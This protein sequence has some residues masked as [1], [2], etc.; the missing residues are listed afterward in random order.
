[1]TKAY[2]KIS[3][4]KRISTKT[5]VPQSE[6]L[7]GRE[8]DMVKNSAGGFVFNVSD[9]TRLDRFLILGSEGGTYYVGEREL[10]ADNANAV[11]AL[12]KKHG[13]K[14][15]ARVVEIS[16]SGRA[17]KNDPALFVLALCMT[18]GDAPTQAAAYA[19]ISQ[20]ARIGTHVLHLADYV[21]NMRGWGRG[22]RRAFGNWYTNQNPKGLAMNL[23]KYTNRDGWTHKDVLRLAHPKSD[24]VYNQLFAYATG[25]PYDFKG[26]DIEGFMNAVE[27]V[28]KATTAQAVKL[29]E[30]YQLPREVLPTELLNEPKV[31]EALLPHMGLTALVR[32][33]A[34]MTRLGLIT[35]TSDTTKLILTKVQSAEE[36]KKARFHPIQALIALKTYAAGHGLRGSNVW[37]PVPRIVDA[38]DG[39]FY[40]SFG[41]IIPTGKRILLALDVSG[42]MSM[43]NVNGIVGL[44]PREVSAAMAMIT[45]KTESEYEI[46]GFSHRFMP[47]DISPRR[48]LD[49]NVRMITGLPFEGTDCALPMV[50][51]TEKAK[52]FDAF[53]IYTDNE[54]WF[55]DI[56][57]IAALKKYRKASGI[58]AKLAVVG[59]TATNFSIA[60]PEDA[61]SMDVVGFDASV[62]NILSDFIRS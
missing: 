49:D 8:S 62:P 39:M 24:G 12:I 58:N 35:A 48:R 53:V 41:N 13:V 28:K 36:L 11:I 2:S 9:F 15:V 42:S 43:D 16:D 33:L 38:L 61:G 31:W 1:M 22:L 30:R 4:R 59:I 21:N 20:V 14:V 19:A 18:H 6:P 60:D 57:P 5:P 26:T 44:S 27:A 34:T 25:K 7:V 37:T 56:H 3:T 55:G 47:L 54:T 51:A 46:M 45:A 29:I 10:T 40:D 52:K 17:P 50:W 32:N 23:V